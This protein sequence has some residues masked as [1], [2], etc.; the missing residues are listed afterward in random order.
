MRAI[1]FMHTF[2]QFIPYYPIT[3]GFEQQLAVVKSLK[4]RICAAYYSCC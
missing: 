1:Q 2:F 4:T 3:N